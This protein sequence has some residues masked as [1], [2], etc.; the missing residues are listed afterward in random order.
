MIEKNIKNLDIKNIS[1]YIINLTESSFSEKG[2][3]SYEYLEMKIKE[4]IKYKADIIDIGAQATNH[5]AELISVEL[6]KE[7]IGKAVKFLAKYRQIN[8]LEYQISV[9]TFRSEVAKVAIECGADIVN[10]ISGGE[11]DH[12]MF[13][14][15]SKYKNIKYIIGHIKGEFETTHSKYDYDDM[16]SELIEYFDNKIDILKSLGIENNRIIIDPCIGFSKREKDNLEILRELDYIMKIIN[17]KYPSVKLLIGISRKK[18]LRNITGDNDVKEADHITSIMHAFIK[19]KSNNI[20][21]RTHNIKYYKEMCDAENSLDIFSNFKYKITEQNVRELLDVNIGVT[22]LKINQEEDEEL[23]NI[24]NARD[25]ISHILKIIKRESR[26]GMTS[27][28]TIGAIYQNFFQ[29]TNFINK[30]FFED[31]KNHIEYNLN[32]ELEKYNLD[33]V[34]FDNV[35]LQDYGNHKKENN[36][37]NKIIPLENKLKKEQGYENKNED[38]FSIPPHQD[39]K[40]FVGLVAVMLIEG[41]SKFYI[42]KDRECNGE[43]YI[44]ASPGDI[45]LMRGYDFMNIKQR[46]IHYIKKLEEGESRISLGFRQY[47]KNPEDYQKLI[48]S[49][50]DGL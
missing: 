47:T 38:K 44:Q 39:Q 25:K 30:N 22:T 48:N 28:P 5:K 27:S 14:L 45:I 8:N 31:L 6:E 33:K 32:C 1:M 42:A 35:I 24:E 18:F 13:K 37:L 34:K 26:I 29:K 12:K 41:D 17:Q 11:L 2:D 23:K 40:G 50:G 21:F 46:P 16:V 36:N 43:K 49:Y 10:D 9:D 4:A 3:A 19:N 15:I 7:L 20:I